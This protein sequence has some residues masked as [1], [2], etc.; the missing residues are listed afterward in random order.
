MPVKKLKPTTPSRRNMSM[1]V[2]DEIT[3]NS[4]IPE[5]FSDLESLFPGITDFLRKNY[6]TI[7]YIYK[8][9]DIKKYK[10]GSN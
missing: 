6:S 5:V 1:L 10:K 7:D 9:M 8:R 4:I 2:N 3:K